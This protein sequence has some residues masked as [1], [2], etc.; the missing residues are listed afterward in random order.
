MGGCGDRASSSA[1]GFGYG[2]TGTGG[3]LDAGSP[4]RSTQPLLAIVDTNQTMN[5]SPGDGVGVFVQYQSGG[6]WDIWWTCDTNKTSESC[7][8]TLNASVSTGSITNAVGPMVTT[9]GGIRGSFSHGD[10]EVEAV[11]VTTTEVDG[12]TF[13][14]PLGATLPIVTVTAWVNGTPSGSFFF[15]VQDGQI[16]GGYTGMLSDPLMFQPSAP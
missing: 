8:F 4:T 6:H 12:M 2:P 15:F 10:Q 1:G 16:N 13:D 3:P 7:S 14:T 11:T 9:D 5:A